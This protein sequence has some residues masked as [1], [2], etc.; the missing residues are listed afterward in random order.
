M[1]VKCRNTTLK[2]DK[3]SI[4]QGKRNGDDQK[5][6]TDEY[7]QFR[8]VNGS[9][10]WLSRVCRPDVS[11]RVSSLQ[12]RLKGLSVADLKECNKVVAFAKGDPDN[13]ADL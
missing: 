4:Q 12:Q 1:H 7:N 6:T 2:M 9:L 11:Y 5:A 8:S 13:G 3:V 10:I